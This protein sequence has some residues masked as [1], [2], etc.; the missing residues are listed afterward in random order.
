MVIGWLCARILASKRT[1]R[2]NSERAG[3]VRSYFAPLVVVLKSLAVSALSANAAF[4]LW[5]VKEVFSNADGSVQFIELF[6]SIGGEQFVA[7]HTLRS[8]SDG[9]IKN[10]VIPGN[11]PNSVDGEHST[12]DRDVQFC[13]P[14][15]GGDAGLSH[16]PSAK[17]F[18]PS[19]QYLISFS[20]QQ[21][22]I[23]S[24]VPCCPRTASTR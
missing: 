16:C 2:H 20:G 1:R 3:D 9:V 7:N 14:A 17:F 5:H 13:Q 22:T 21:R 15:R 6:D 8:N 23:D 11:L 24:R 19:Q 18:N 10:F 12:F 4:H